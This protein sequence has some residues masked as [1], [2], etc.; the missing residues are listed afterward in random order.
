MA[1]EAA[2]PALPITT[3]LELPGMRIDQN[4]GLCFGLVVRSVGIAKG[5][6]AA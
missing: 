2:G 6:T 3:A 4:L 1:D 5:F